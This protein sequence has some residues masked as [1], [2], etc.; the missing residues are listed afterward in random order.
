MISG[1]T[2]FRHGVHQRRRFDVPNSASWEVQGASG[3]LLRCRDNC[4]TVVFAQARCGVQV[5]S[6]FDKKNYKQSECSISI[7]LIRNVRR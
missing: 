5:C 1:Q 3:L 4:G 7:F 2:L 6:R